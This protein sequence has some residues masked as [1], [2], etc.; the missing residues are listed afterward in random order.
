M[1]LAFAVL[2]LGRNGMEVIT[3]HGEKR[4]HC[5]VTWNM[6]TTTDV[7]PKNWNEQVMGELNFQDSDR[8][9]FIR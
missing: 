3:Q 8:T 6:A 4:R 5:N 1:K 2:H 7:P 9:A